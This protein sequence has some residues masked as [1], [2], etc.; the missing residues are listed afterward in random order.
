MEG[1]KPNL[2]MKT[3]GA[4]RTTGGSDVAKDGGKSTGGADIKTGKQTGGANISTGKQTGSSDVKRD[5]SKTSGLNNAFKSG[6]KVNKRS[7]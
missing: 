6:G 4:V 3:G 5:G 1:F 2:K 7:C